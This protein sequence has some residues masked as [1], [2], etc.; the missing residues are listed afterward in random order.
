MTEH[1]ETI[2]FFSRTEK[3]TSNGTIEDDRPVGG[4]LGGTSLIAEEHPYRV[5]TSKIN[6]KDS[7]IFENF[8]E[9]VKVILPYFANA[10]RRAL[11][12]RPHK[13]SLRNIHVH[14]SEI[15]VLYKDKDG[16][17]SLAAP[18]TRIFLAQG[19]TVNY[20]HEEPYMPISPSEGKTIKAKHVIHSYRRVV[21]KNLA[22]SDAAAK[23]KSNLYLIITRTVSSELTPENNIYTFSLIQLDQLPPV[24]YSDVEV[25]YLDS[26]NLYTIPVRDINDKNTVI[27]KFVVATSVSLLS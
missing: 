6:K 9:T 3:T 12:L 4:G 2:N 10:N 11:C 20:Q 18:D 1:E 8:A 13:S 23:L 14:M 22:R 27:A 19:A 5:L 26:N 17:R 24:L 15:V 21:L 16:V 25:T 7:P